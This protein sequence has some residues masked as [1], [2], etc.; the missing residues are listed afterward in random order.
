M[1]EQPS[2]SGQE[3]DE[4]AGKESLDIRSLVYEYL[5]SQ[6]SDK[7][8]E[9]RKERERKEFDFSLGARRGAIGVVLAAVFFLY[10]QLYRIISNLSL[11]QDGNTTALTAL[12]SGIIISTTALLYFLLANIFR[13]A[14]KDKP[15][16][17]LERFL[18]N[19]VI[20]KIFNL[21]E[22]EQSE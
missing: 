6:S 3:T 20:K 1:D 16:H 12:V 10:L 17:P 7:A 22:Q 4:Q 9:I 19:P 15:A 13:N 5:E 14:G 18:N 2:F 11:L 21:S 8:E